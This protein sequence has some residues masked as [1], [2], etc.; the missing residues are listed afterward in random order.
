MLVYF[1]VENF[2][3]FNERVCLDMRAAPRLRRLS[4]HVRKPL[5]G[6]NKSLK[7]LKTALIYGANASGKSNLLKAIKFAEEMITSSK[8]NKRTI[9]TQPFLMA[10]KPRED[11]EFEFEFTVGEVYFGYS[12]K[13][14]SERVVGEHLYIISGDDEMTVYNRF[15]DGDING[16]HIEF[17]EM[18]NEFFSAEQM[19][20]FEILSKHCPKVKLILNECFEWENKESLGD[21]GTLLNVSHGFFRYYLYII[22]PQTRYFGLLKDINDVEHSESFIKIL[23]NF[24]TGI[25]SLRASPV[26]QSRFDET[27]IENVSNKLQELKGKSLNFKFDGKEYQAHWSD[28]DELEIF[29]LNSVHNVPGGKEKIFDLKEES[30]GTLRLLDLIPALR[31][32]DPKLSATFIIDEFDR[33]LHPLLSRSFIENFINKFNAEN[34]NQLIVTTHQSELLDNEL[35]RRDEIWFVQKEWDQSSKLYSLDEY[36]TRF[37]KDIQKAYLSGRFGAIPQIKRV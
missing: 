15:F 10:D 20:E 27:F 18:A 1:S 23:N 7:V 8:G 35:L 3:S 17:D 34:D 5:S 19:E 25:D 9:N 30:D 33:S 28:K 21:L 14:N 32:K 6:K 24:D 16:Y 36:S 37:D 12:F 31:N 26:E 13:L 29:T 22:F 11:S 4:N 2:R